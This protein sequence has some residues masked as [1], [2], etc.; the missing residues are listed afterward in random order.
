MRRAASQMT[1][2]RLVTCIS[3]LSDTPS[4]LRRSSQVCW[5]RGSRTGRLRPCRSTDRVLSRRPVTGLPWRPPVVSIIL[6][7]R[8]RRTGSACSPGSPP[9]G[10]TS[11]TAA[12]GV[13]RD[14]RNK[15]APL[16]PRARANGR[17]P[18][19]IIM[20]GDAHESD[21]RIAALADGALPILSWSPDPLGTR[22]PRCTPGSRG[23]PCPHD[24]EGR[25][26]RI[27]F[28][29]VHRRRAQPCLEGKL[30]DGRHQDHHAPARV[31]LA[32]GNSCP[33]H[34]R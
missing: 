24:G 21:R 22:H 11:Q 23:L 12:T 7:P 25:A 27:R 26:A 4:S 14:S 8:L 29:D 16:Q 10:K 5:R 32:A 1:D 31:A 2:L 9:P 28:L 17:Q 13:G 33:P 30:R 20:A 6:M 19:S 18:C 3:P 15:A 34:R